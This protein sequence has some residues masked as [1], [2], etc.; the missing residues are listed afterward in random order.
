MTSTW[1]GYDWR[2]CE[3]APKDPREL[4]RPGC[5]YIFVRA[6]AAFF[7]SWLP[8]MMYWVC[9]NWNASIPASLFGAALVLFDMLNVTEARFILVDSQLIFWV[10]AA[11]LIAQ[12]WWRRQNEHVLAT[13]AFASAHGR[14]Y[15]GGT[16]DYELAGRD[17]RLMTPMWRFLWCCACGFVFAN[18]FSVKWT[19]L[20][21]PGGWRA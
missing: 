4:Y 5:K 17:A 9:R 15:N 13:E 16:E 14:E 6:T 20:A 21:T 1:V 19:G 2:E 7:G 3:F 11:L 12:N 8:V 10:A 18:A